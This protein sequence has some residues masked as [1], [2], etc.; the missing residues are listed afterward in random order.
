MMYI[1]IYIYMY[2]SYMNIFLQII[3]IIE[4]LVYIYINRVQYDEMKS[5]G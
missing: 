5:F 4:S 1:Y 2:I 3:S